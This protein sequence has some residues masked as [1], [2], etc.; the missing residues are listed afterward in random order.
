MATVVDLLDGV[1][2]DEVV[3]GA[4]GLTAGRLAEAASAYLESQ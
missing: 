2:Q 3:S 1:P 4:D